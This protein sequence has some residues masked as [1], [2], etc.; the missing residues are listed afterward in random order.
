MWG[1]GMGGYGTHDNQILLRLGLGDEVDA[2]HATCA[3]FVGDG[4]GPQVLPGTFREQMR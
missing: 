3:G 4:D 2:C 1:H